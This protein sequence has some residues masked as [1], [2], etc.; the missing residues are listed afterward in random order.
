MNDYLKKQQNDDLREQQRKFEDYSENYRKEANEVFRELNRQLILFA[1]AV[2]SISLFIFRNDS[3]YKQIFILDKH[4]LVIT[5]ILLGISILAGIIQFFIDYF[6][7]KKWAKAKFS[8]VEGIVRGEINKN[9]IF[10]K[11]V[12]KQQ[13][14]PSESSNIAIWIESISLVLA[15]ILIIL[16]MSRIIFF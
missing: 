2:L 14:I 10:S 9:N 8:I 11:V 12:E 16:M 1:T 6:F 4:L 3:F 7:F 15:L 5:W 13:N